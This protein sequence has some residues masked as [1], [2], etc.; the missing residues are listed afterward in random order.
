MRA[1]SR[2][3]RCQGIEAAP[4]SQN[5]TCDLMDISSVDTSKLRFVSSRSGSA[6]RSANSVGAED[7]SRQVQPL[8]QRLNETVSRKLD[9]IAKVQQVFLDA[10]RMGEDLQKQGILEPIM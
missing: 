5:Q 1:T 9:G 4:H 3:P 10:M 8:A 2:I 6:K 7:P